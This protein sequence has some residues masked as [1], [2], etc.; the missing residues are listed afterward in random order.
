MR[1][2]DGFLPDTQ[3]TLDRRRGY[4]VQAEVGE[5]GLSKERHGELCPAEP[6]WPNWA[7]T[8]SGQSSAR[9]PTLGRPRSFAAV[10]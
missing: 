10:S 4:R 6:D 1:W 8:Q 3:W 5:L 7:T 9:S 2:P